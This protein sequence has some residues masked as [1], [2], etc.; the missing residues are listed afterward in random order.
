MFQAA[1]FFGKHFTS[2]RLQ[3]T[4]AGVPLEHLD[5]VVAN[6]DLSPENGPKP[7]KAEYYGGE[8]RLVNGKEYNA[9]IAVAGPTPG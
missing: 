9:Y 6:I 4:S 3:I 1:E 5:R 7:A 8:K 2:S